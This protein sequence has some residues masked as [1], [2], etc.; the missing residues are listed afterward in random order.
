MNYGKF[1]KLNLEESKVVDKVSVYDYMD[2]PAYFG[3]P[4]PMSPKYPISVC[5]TQ[6]AL[7]FCLHYCVYHKKGTCQFLYTIDDKPGD[8][9][10]I[11]MQEVFFR[12]SLCKSLYATDI[13]CNQRII[14]QLF[15]D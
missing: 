13:R 10:T 14:H 11:H 9:E 15:P 12:D 6:D 2:L 5:I 7:R 8:I 3:N 4:K 1:F